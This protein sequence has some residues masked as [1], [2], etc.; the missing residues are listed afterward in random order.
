[1]SRALVLGG[2]GGIGG[3]V[4]QAIN[5]ESGRGAAFDAIDV[6]DVRS[7]AP[8]ASIGQVVP[9]R[10]TLHTVDLADDV[11]RD[12]WF[13]K[14]LADVG[15][16]DAVAWCAGRYP[17]RDIREYST[18][19]L[20][21]VLEIN[22]TALLALLP[23]LVNS[24]LVGGRPLRIVVVGS[25]AGVTGGLDVPYA[26]AKA[27]LVAAVK[28]IAR[29]YAK[30]GITANVVSPGPVETPMAGVMGDER[31]RFYES[32]IPLGRYSRADE[33]AS[34]IAWLLTDAPEAVTGMVLDVD[35]G[36]VRR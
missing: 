15:T 2:L 34:V 7:A 32:T 3:A 31:R 8:A 13:G 20:R 4:C 24:A 14:Y 5:G 22:L 35:G 10:T 28:S 11:S 30:A 26:A 12:A 17:R 19:E 16:P 27:G 21:G 25:Q 1:M 36:L 18:D 29:E 6:V 9:G 33:V 23:P